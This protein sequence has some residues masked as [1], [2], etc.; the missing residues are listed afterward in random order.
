MSVL[1]AI[2]MAFSCFSTIPMPRITWDEKNM[3]Y[4]MA[5]FP[6][7]GVVVGLLVCGWR[8]LSQALGFGTL[9]TAAGTTLLPLVVTGGIH[10]DGFAD[11]MDAQSSHASAERRREIMRDPHIGA[12]AAM[13]VSSYLIAYCALASELGARD[14]VMIG[15][16]PVISRCL[17]GFA[18]V[19]FRTSSEQ[20]MLASEQAHAHASGVR[21][22]LATIFALAALLMMR[23]NPL[24][25]IV[26]LCAALATLVWV[27][28]LAD[29]YYGGMSGD[30]A[31][32]FLQVVE[33]TML[34]CIVTVGKL[35]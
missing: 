12:F 6:L 25:A 34:A 2:I 7:V 35:V 10:L 14:L 8:L 20:G 30:L 4:M 17:S 19:T 33:A 32:F 9:L 5:A 1:T 16:V 28:H 13:A 22:A 24:G 3:R 26:S 23:V 29:T 11:V 15:C 18:T 27:K 21:V 31:G